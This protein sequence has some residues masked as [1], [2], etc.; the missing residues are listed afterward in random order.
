MKQFWQI[1]AL[2]LAGGEVVHAGSFAYLSPTA[3]AATNKTLFVACATASR[4]LSF[5]LAAGKVS[6]FI[7]VPDVP[8]GLA[9]ST[10]EQ[11]LY[12][13]CAA[14]ESKICVIDT[15]QRK[16]IK[17]FPA[18]HT[19][20]APVI[21][22]DGK[23]LYVCNRFNNDVS[24]LDVVTGKEQCRIPVRREPVAAAITPDGMYLLVANHL[25]T[26]RADVDYV[27]AEVSVIDTSSKRVIK[28]LQLPNGS[29]S[30]NG[31][32]I[33]P[34]GRYAAVTH[35]VGRFNRLTTRV[36]D[37]WMNVNALT[38]IDLT[39]MKVHG[40]MLLDDY[41]QGAA[42]PWGAAWSADG[43]KL[44][45]THAGEQEVSVIDFPN[46]LKQMPVLPTD[47]NPAKVADVYAKTRSQSQL[48]DD[49][50]FFPGSRARVRLPGGDLGPRAVV[51]TGNRAYV[52]NYFSDTLTEIDLNKAH[53]QGESIALGPRHEM[54]EVRQGEFY[55][56]DAG[57]CYE[58]WQSCASCHPDDGRP[59]GLNWDLL[60]DG[61]GNP[62]NTKS[63]LLVN[64]TPPAMYLG[65]RGNAESAVRAGLLH[66][67]FTQQ[68]NSVA[69]AINDYLKSLKPVP[70][71]YLVDGKLSAAAQQ[72]EKVFQQAGCA[73]CHVPGLFTDLQPH[74]VGT[75]RE[76]DRPTDKFYTP[77]LVEVW[78]T[79]P[80]L[81][82]GSAATM[83]DVLTTRNAKGQHGNV[84]GLT[85]QELD[86]LC[87]Y[88]LS[89]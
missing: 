82:D 65:V 58:K 32:A 24:V 18:G 70:S 13:T 63:L 36:T 21:S 81:H 57:L 8:T 42:N 67:L 29:T 20:M 11:R 34:D 69:V 30:L 71:P 6:G 50:P 49:L 53:P 66:I 7:T 83:R 38:L 61:I 16:I 4:V 80:Y 3:M 51:I 39:K 35:I 44:V 47:Y 75:N 64:Q 77:T 86:N 85:D 1:L 23:T 25:P 15:V 2:V 74:N 27:A 14:P 9:L 31:L 33:S 41:S 5:D 55:F 68:P 88:V 37:G 46:L 78:R 22:P 60:N 28:E 87:E 19:A 43:S 79:A 73:D 84:E 12:V 40:T 59:D 54:N 89:L 52:A 45:V 72:G 62:K 56:N 17:T 10:D 48:P 26:G 76:F